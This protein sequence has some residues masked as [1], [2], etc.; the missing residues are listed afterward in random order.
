MDLIAQYS[1]SDEEGCAEVAAKKKKSIQD[2]APE[3]DTVG[4][5]LSTENNAVVRV[6]EEAKY[7]EPTR[8]VVYEN[9]KH[10]ELY[11]PLA[12]P[13]NAYDAAGLNDGGQKH[14]DKNKNKRKR[15]FPHIEGNFPTWVY[16][17]LKG[18][19]KRA[20]GGR[21]VDVD[22]IQ[23]LVISLMK[24]MKVEIFPIPESPLHISLSRPVAIRA[25][26]IDTFTSMLRKAFRR[27]KPFECNLGPLEVLLNDD[28]STCFIVFALESSVSKN[29]LSLDRLV[30]SVDKVFH[31]HSLQQYYTERRHHISLA[32]APAQAF[33]T[34]KEACLKVNQRSLM[35][36]HKVERIRR[37]YLIYVDNIHCKIGQQVTQV[38]QQA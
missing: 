14:H 25:A 3:V 35:I 11:A 7:E 29:N 16:V 19:H 33:S 32:W 22:V 36:G 2:A 31:K 15:V 4:L 26:Q 13:S 23:N 18:A 30:D 38:S 10:K 37:A 1:D 27:F 20:G 28:G 21:D 5:G 34:L 12:G 6:G 24:Q 8:R 17:R 9:L